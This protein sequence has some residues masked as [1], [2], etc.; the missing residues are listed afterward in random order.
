MCNLTMPNAITIHQIICVSPLQQ[1]VIYLLELILA[2]LERLSITSGR[3]AMLSSCNFVCFLPTLDTSRYTAPPTTS[4][5]LRAAYSRKCTH[6]IGTCGPGS[7]SD[8]VANPVRGTELKKYSAGRLVMIKNGLQ[9][10]KV[11][12]QNSCPI[13]YKIWSPRSKND[14]LAVYN[15]LGQSIDRYPQKP[16]LIVDVSRALDKC[17]T[18]DTTVMRGTVVHENWWRTTDGS[19]WWLRDSIFEQPSDQYRANCFLS[20]YD[21]Q[22]DNVRFQY[23]DDGE[24]AASSDYLCQPKCEHSAHVPPLSPPPHHPTRPPPPH[25][26]T[27]SQ[28]TQQQL[29]HVNIISQSPQYTYSLAETILIHLSCRRSYPTGLMLRPGNTSCQDSQS[30]SP[31]TK[32]SRA[33]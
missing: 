10:N 24:C 21:V 18:C 8:C 23:H 15:A 33:Q 12:Q 28:F 16:N 22:P 6:I 1:I 25:A 17:D 27:Q 26:H 2:C 13:G 31:T 20:V 30:I 7:P 5:L 3:Y 19:P 9:V 14:W 4:N 32:R 11:N 29:I